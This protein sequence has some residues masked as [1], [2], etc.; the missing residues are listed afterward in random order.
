MDSKPTTLRPMRSHS[1]HTSILSILDVVLF[2][3]I[4]ATPPTLSSV[5]DAHT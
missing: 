5:Q 3:N 2:M 4:Y 1:T